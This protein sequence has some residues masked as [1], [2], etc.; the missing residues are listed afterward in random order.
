MPPKAADYDSD[1]P[2]DGHA[3][4]HG[5]ESGAEQPNSGLN[6]LLQ[7]T[8]RVTETE[9]DIFAAKPFDVLIRMFMH[10]LLAPAFCYNTR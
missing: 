8:A 2:D 5:S 4:E 3:S 7:L 6:P 10:P 9:G 1:P